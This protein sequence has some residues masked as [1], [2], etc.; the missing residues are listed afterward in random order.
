MTPRPV[1]WPAEGP[2]CAPDGPGC[3]YVTTVAEPDELTARGVNPERWAGRWHWC[4]A[5]GRRQLEMT[6]RGEP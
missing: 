2:A 1:W 4:A 6:W 3:L 5:H